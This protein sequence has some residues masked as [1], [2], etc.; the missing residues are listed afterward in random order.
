MQHYC[1]LLQSIKESDWAKNSFLI[2]ECGVKLPIDV[3]VL[4]SFWLRFDEM[5][6]SSCYLGDCMMVSLPA[7]IVTITLFR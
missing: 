7:D 3:A 5:N 2:S 6:E 4:W 1:E